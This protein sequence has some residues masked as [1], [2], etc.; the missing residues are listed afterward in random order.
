MN[1]LNQ[2]KKKIDLRA[3]AA[4][5]G[6]AIDRRRTCANSCKM[7][8]ASGY[9]IVIARD[10]NSKDYIYFSI[11]NA[12]DSGTIIDFLQNRGVKGWREIGD[13]LRGFLGLPLPDE[14][15]TYG[16]LKASKKDIQQ[17]VLDYEKAEWA[18]AAP[19]LV[20][21]G[22]PAALTGS[23]RF[24]NCFKVDWR[25]NV[26]FPHYNRSGLSG[27]EKKNY[28]FTGFASGGVKGLWSSICYK[29]DTVLVITESAI[30]ALSYQVLNPELTSARFLSIGGSMNPDQLELLTLAMKKMKN[31]EI[32]LALDND[33]DGEKMTDQVRGLALQGTRITRPLPQSKDWNQDLKNKLRL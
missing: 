14:I 26:L 2:F 7:R 16:K 18:T 21:R 27:F 6:F 4:S 11:N 10:E 24:K 23:H 30:D 22:I 13:T 8:D 31:G 29:A 20:S 3:F 5:Y 32:R 9:Q 1:D 19:Y 25:G 12:V 33:T 17:A 15:A 28:D